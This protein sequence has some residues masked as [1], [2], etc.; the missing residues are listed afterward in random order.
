MIYKV[1]LFTNFQ[2]NA[3]M[4]ITAATSAGDTAGFTFKCWLCGTFKRGLGS[5]RIIPKQVRICLLNE[6]QG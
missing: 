6:M 1:R 2:R 3:I 5:R 4:E